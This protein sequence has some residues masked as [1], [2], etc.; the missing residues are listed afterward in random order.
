MGT[1][2]GAI[3]CVMRIKGERWEFHIG[4]TIVIVENAWRWSGYS[5]ERVRVNDEVHFDRQGWFWMVANATTVAEFATL[6]DR[7]RVVMGVKYILTGQ[8]LYCRV[9]SENEVIEPTAFLKGKWDKADYLW[10][11]DPDPF[12]LNNDAQVWREVKR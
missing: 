9:V 2:F 10:P 4:N 3:G 11:P 1:H 6:E 8:H 5:Q 7:Y 12:D